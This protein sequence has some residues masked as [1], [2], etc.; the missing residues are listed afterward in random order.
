M[1]KDFDR[2]FHL[3]PKNINL[4]LNTEDRDLEILESSFIITFLVSC[5]GFLSQTYNEYDIIIAHMD[6][7][8]N[9]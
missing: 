4:L 1:L 8:E 7:V 3:R 2:I 6:L 9:A 5:L